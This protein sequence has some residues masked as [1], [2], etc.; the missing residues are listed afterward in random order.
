MSSRKFRVHST[1]VLLGPLSSDEWNAKEHL[2]NNA[3]INIDSKE[4]PGTNNL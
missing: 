2:E 4:V 3:Y 1:D